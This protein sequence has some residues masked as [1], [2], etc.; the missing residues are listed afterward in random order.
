MFVCMHGGISTNRGINF[1]LG[2]IWMVCDPLSSYI[3][4]LLKVPCMCASMCI[5][6]YLCVCLSL[7][8]YVDDS[9]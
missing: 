1:K 2:L 6:V 5:Y 3:T 9:M 4:I 7:Y 8:V